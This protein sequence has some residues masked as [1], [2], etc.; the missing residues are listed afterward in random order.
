MIDEFQKQAVL[1]GLKRMFDGPRFDIC[2]V[3]H[4]LTIIGTYLDKKDEAAMSALHC[5][6]FKDMSPDLRKMLFV[7]VME[8]LSAEPSFNTELISSA[9]DGGHAGFYG[10]LLN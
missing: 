1:L 10:R 4:A 2:V 5:I 7:K 3:R 9:L 6:D 8:V